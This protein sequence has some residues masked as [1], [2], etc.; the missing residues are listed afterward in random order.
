MNQHTRIPRLPPAQQMT[1]RQF[2]AFTRS[3]PDDERWE[4]ME[5]VPVLRPSATDFHQ[6]VVGNITI[7]LMSEKLRLG[8]GWLALA[9]IGTK[10]PISPNSLP[11][12][13][14]F[15]MEGPPTGRHLT[16]DALVI[17]EVLSR[18]NTRSDREWRHR[19]YSSVPNCQHYVTI[20]MKAP[21]LTA[22]DRAGAWQGREVAG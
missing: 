1:I 19:A 6:I 11:Q 21:L 15:V 12:P 22:Y 4:L 13:D 16:D 7:F 18:S 8:A 9:G 20:S 3:R 17:F 14:V 2:L 10:V 5:G